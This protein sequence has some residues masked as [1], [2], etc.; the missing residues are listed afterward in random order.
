MSHLFRSNQ[1]LTFLKGNWSKLGNIL[2]SGELPGRVALPMMNIIV[3]K[4]RP[5]SLIVSP[6]ARV[7]MM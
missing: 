3:L 4:S 6:L 5:T 2:S 7:A 1:T